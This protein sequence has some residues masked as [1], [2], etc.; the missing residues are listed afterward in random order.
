MFINQKK[1]K[2]KKTQH[3][4]KSFLQELFVQM[5]NKTC[6]VPAGALLW[7]KGYSGSR[8][9]SSQP[10]EQRVLFS[11]TSSWKHSGYKWNPIGRRHGIQRPRA[12]NWNHTKAEGGG[13]GRHRW[14][15]CPVL[16][17]LTLCVYMFICMVCTFTPQGADR[18]KRH[19]LYSYISSIRTTQALQRTKPS[20]Y[21]KGHTENR[22]LLWER[23]TQM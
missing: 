10:T 14:A 6:F 7:I 22:A 20:L 3:K 4:N 17:H 2:Q 12:Q 21:T 19:F 15:G 11:I 8:F 9:S 1:K 18:Y 23:N 16:W 13:S 5:R